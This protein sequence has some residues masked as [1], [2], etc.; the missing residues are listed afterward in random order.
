MK[1]TLIMLKTGRPKDLTRLAQFLEEAI[2]SK[3]AFMR[4]VDRFSLREKWNQF[5]L[6]NFD[7]HEPS[8]PIP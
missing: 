1:K 3:G 7:D 5:I 2:L 6:R 4:L 8:F